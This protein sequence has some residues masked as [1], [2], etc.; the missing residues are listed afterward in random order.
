MDETNA[1]TKL[2]NYTKHA[3]TNIT[4]IQASPKKN[5]KY[6]FHKPLDK[7]KTLKPKFLLR[8]LCRTADKKN[9]L[10]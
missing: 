9:I 2:Y 6:V 8:G 3:A 10:F 1:V 7:I 5:E 4:T